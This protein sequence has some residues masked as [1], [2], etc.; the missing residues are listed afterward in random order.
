MLNSP[1]PY[2]RD[3]ANQPQ[4]THIHLNHSWSH[5]CTVQIAACAEPQPNPRLDKHIH[6]LKWGKTISHTSYRSAIAHT[7]PPASFTQACVHCADRGLCRATAQPE[8]G[9]TAEHSQVGQGLW[10][11][12]QGWCHAHAGGALAWPGPL[13]KHCCW[14]KVCSNSMCMAWCDNLCFWVTIHIHIYV[15]VT[16]CLRIAFFAMYVTMCV[17]TCVCEYTCMWRYMQCYQLSW[18]TCTEHAE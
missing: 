10:V 1:K 5:S 14:R 3:I 17:Y 15:Y 16:K 6:I 18:R 8:A 2:C 7:L 13:G 11:D 4:C 9:H 12:G